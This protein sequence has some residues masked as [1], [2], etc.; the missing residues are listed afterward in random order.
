M[1]KSN[2]IINR[3]LLLQAYQTIHVLLY[4]Y[5]RAWSSNLITYQ[6]V[7]NEYQ[8]KIEI[9]LHDGLFAIESV[10]HDFYDNLEYKY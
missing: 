3:I 10:T 5:S 8:Q 2:C 7:H 6:Y 1:V 9:I 4:S